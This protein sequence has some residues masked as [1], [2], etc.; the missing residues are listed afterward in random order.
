MTNKEVQGLVD[1]HEPFLMRPIDESLRIEKRNERLR[2]KKND[3]RMNGRLCKK[4]KRRKR[5][6]RNVNEKKKKH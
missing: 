1:Y 6:R 3:E 5:K 2:K 4:P